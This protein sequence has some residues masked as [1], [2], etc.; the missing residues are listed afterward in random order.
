MLDETETEPTR[1]KERRAGVQS[2]HRAFRLL[3]TIAVTREGIGLADL[4]KEVGLHSSTAFHLVKTLVS[5][6]YVKQSA[7]TRKYHLAPMVYGLAA[8][9][10][11]EIELVNVASPILDALARTTGESAHLGIRTGSDVIV[12]ARFDA[13]S[14]VQVS[15]RTSGLRPA[16]ATALGKILMSALPADELDHFLQNYVFEPLTTQT[17]VDPDRFRR[18]LDGVRRSGIAFDDCEFNSEMRCLAVPVWDFTG[19]IVAAVGISG[20]IWRLNLQALHDKAAVVNKAAAELSQ[21]L[22][23]RSEAV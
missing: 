18:E 15:I 10:L 12:A 7:H 3:E 11:D 22:G 19:V 1:G 17:I 4:A 23:H 9:A 16:H 21:Q 20:P 13:P 5:L 8:N 2:L 14:N 6:G